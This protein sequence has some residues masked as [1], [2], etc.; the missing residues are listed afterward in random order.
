[1]SSLTR[2][3]FGSYPCAS[4]WREAKEKRQIDVQRHALIERGVHCLLSEDE[5][6]GYDVQQTKGAVEKTALTRN[7]S[8]ASGLSSTPPRETVATPPCEKEQ[9][10]G[11]LQPVIPYHHLSK[12]IYHSSK[13]HH[14]TNG[15]LFC[16]VNKYV[17]LTIVQRTDEKNGCFSG[18]QAGQG[19]LRPSLGHILREYGTIATEVD[20]GSESDQ[21]VLKK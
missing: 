9:H 1:V 17:V 12:S 15:C 16:C 6:V 19:R 3:R 2:E 4:L 5:H 14:G 8:N 10:G 13:S 18:G 7:G 20:W 21:V 11:I